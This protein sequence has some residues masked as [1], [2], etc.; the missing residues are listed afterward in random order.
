MILIVCALM[1]EAKP[2]IAHLRLKKDFS[3]KE[4]ELFLGEETELIVSGI[5]KI[6]AAIAT[7][8][9]LARH[10]GRTDLCLINIGICGSVQHCENGAIYLVNKITDNATGKSFFPD[11]LLKHALPEASLS[12]YDT[13]VSKESGHELSSDLVDME[14]AGILIAAQM[15]LYPH[16]ILCLKIVSDR[17]EGQPLSK[18]LIEN[19][20]NANLAAIEQVIGGY[21]RFVCSKKNVLNCA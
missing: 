9:L 1:A 15:Y 20:F 11:I 3:V 13:P 17:L 19:L 18:G 6:K 8:A 12:T 7:T 21:E 4:H 10:K 16:Q 2:L 14:A 5:G